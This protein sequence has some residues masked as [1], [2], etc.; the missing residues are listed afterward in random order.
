MR[1]L[2]T[3]A[4]ALAVLALCG[5]G[6][7][8]AAD[9][10]SGQGS[11]FVKPMMDKWVQEYAKDHK[12]LEIN[13]QSTGSG[14]GIKAVVDMANDF[15]CS[16]AFMKK[17]DLEK[18]AAAGGPVLHIPLV[19]GAVVPAYNLPSV[20]EPLNFDGDALAGIFLGKITKWNDPAIAA[21]NQ[22]VTLPDLPIA[23]VHRSDGSGT[24]FVFA[25]FLTLTNDA[26]KS[27]RG[28]ATTHRLEERR[29]GRERQRGRAPAPSARAKAPSATWN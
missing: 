6:A 16:D 29:H 5:V 21:L 2:L 8:S 9:K 13:Y 15:G 12:D 25:S 10:I 24:T 28:A 4:A 14:A 17:E 11:T 1:S 26:W 19:M 23:V 18:A 27:E 3:S 22:G 7:A 20:K